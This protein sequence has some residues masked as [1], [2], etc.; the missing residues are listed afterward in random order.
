MSPR[1]ERQ[2]AT[3]H[4]VAGEENIEVGTSI[5][6]DVHPVRDLFH[7]AA[8]PPTGGGVPE[9][10]PQQATPAT[11]IGPSGRGRPCD[12]VPRN[13]GSGYGS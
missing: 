1:A 12:R 6:V 4:L 10:L 3:S 13:V 5:P 11:G 9:V 8:D 2:R 7:L